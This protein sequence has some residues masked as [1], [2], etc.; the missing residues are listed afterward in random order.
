MKRC[1]TSKHREHCPKEVV[2]CSYAKVGCKKEMVREKCKNHDADNLECHLQLAVDRISAL[3]SKMREP[4]VPVV[5]KLSDFSKLKDAYDVWYSG[6]FYSHP[7]G[8]RMT[9]RVDAN[10]DGEE[11]HSCLSV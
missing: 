7:R 1:D 5:F 3:Q 8:Y 2:K 10:G 9:L 6:T 4:T 11:D